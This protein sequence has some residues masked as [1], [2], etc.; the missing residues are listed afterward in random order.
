MTTTT[1]T[2]GGWTILSN[3]FHGTEYRTRKTRED[4]DRIDQ[5]NPW[6]RTEA[7]RAFVRR[8]ARALCGS[9]EC[10]CATNSFGE[11]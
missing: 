3:S 9:K 1:T 4:L 11:R 5:T 2:T 6:D 7:E 8:A 10:R